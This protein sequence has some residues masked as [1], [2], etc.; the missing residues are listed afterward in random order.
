M[1]IKLKRIISLLLIAVSCLSLFACGKNPM[2]AA[3][4]KAAVWGQY[5]TV[6]ILRDRTD[7]EKMD[8]NVEIEMAKNEI[9]SD[10]IIISAE[11]DIKSYEIIKSDLI[12]ES[13]DKLA[14][15][16]IEIF[17]QHYIRLQKK[18]NGGNFPIGWYPDALI[19]LDKAALKGENSIKAGNNQ[20]ITITVTSPKDMK[21]GIYSGVFQLK[22]ADKLQNIPVKVTVW[23][24][25][26]PEEVHLQSSFDVRRDWLMMGELDNSDEMYAEYCKFMNKNRLSTVWLPG[27]N[28]GLINDKNMLDIPLFVEAAKKAAV[29]PSI[30]TYNIPVVYKPYHDKVENREAPGI[31]ISA[32]KEI[33]TALAKASTKDADLIRK[34]VMYPYG[35]VD[36][37]QFSNSERHA[38]NLYKEM[39]KMLTEVIEEL[40]VTENGN[41]FE[42]RPTLKSSIQD[43]QILITCHITSELD[44]NVKTWV[45]QISYLG[46][47]KERYEYESRRET[48][49]SNTWYYTCYQPYYPYPGLMIDLDLIDARVMQWMAKDYNLD[50]YLYWSVNSYGIANNGICEPR[51][52]YNDPQAFIGAAANGDGYL[53]YPGVDYGVKGPISSLR[54][55]AVRDGFEDYEYLWL[56]ED[57]IEKSQ[58]TFGKSFDVDAITGK[59]YDSLYSGVIPNRIAQNLTQARREVA[60]LVELLNS[61]SKAIALI[62][63]IDANT[64]TAVL[65][66]YAAVGTTLKINGEDV[67]GTAC[68]D[69]L[70]FVYTLSLDQNKNFA[71]YEFTSS[72]KT[73]KVSKFISGAL[74]AIS[75]FDSAQQIS[76][77]TVSNG[78]ETT[79]ANH[80]QALLNTNAAYAK[81]GASMQV[82]VSGIDFGDDLVSEL[83]YKTKIQLAKPDGFSKIDFTEID[84]LEFFIFNDSADFEVSVELDN[85]MGETYS[86]TQLKLKKGVWTNVNIGQI[87]NCGWSKLGDVTKINIIFPTIKTTQTPLTVYIDNM[88]CSV[89]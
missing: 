3:E 59:I 39:E 63:S 9:E 15:E 28:T 60:A 89:K 55:E 29:N 88:Y 84:T 4:E 37:P 72:G 36:E 71:N 65:K 44:G 74:K 69:G 46:T 12:S 19:P 61:E 13:G 35:I 24:F 47:E 34:M 62:D 8:G 54:L 52:P 41:F 45:P 77:W 53:V 31:D 17:M 81:A 42:N 70:E 73:R 33:M 7:C 21:S 6:K 48:D 85:G 64:N 50:G 23:D 56:L 68:K 43:F 22:Y 30:S 78:T 25:A 83:N 49:G 20:G 26:I 10:Q 18:S 27:Q 51:D 2:P 67:K 86:L 57:L 14:K 80:V 38:V 5:N 58:E 76:A 1:T 11:T 32:T 79:P 75:S 40:K 87:Y 82:N 66:S 16:N